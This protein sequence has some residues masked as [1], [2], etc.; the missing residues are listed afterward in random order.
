MDGRFNLNSLDLNLLRIFRAIHVTGSVSRAGQ[1][2]GMTQ[3]AVSNAL[4]RL[5]AQ[6]GDPLFVRSPT[7]VLPTAMADALIGPVEE[8][9]RQFESAIEGLQTF[10]PALS[11]RCFRIYVNDLAQLVFMPRL[12][13]Y[14][15]THA[16]HIQFETV[17]Q[18]V[19][20]GRR[21]MKEGQI[22]LA[23]ANWPAMGEGY[24]RQRLFSETFV[25]VMSAGNS[26]ARKRLS[27]TDYLNASHLDYRPSGSTYGVLRSILDTLFAREKVS[28]Q[29][30]FAAAHALGLARI[31]ADSELLLTIP[32]RLAD[33]L[34]QGST[35]AF[36]VK[37]LPFAS[38]TLQ[39]TQQWHARVQHDPANRWL[40]KLILDIF[41]DG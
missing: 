8:G 37:R 39:V 40:R 3:S 7:G 14:A 20:V 22:D 41:R 26:L 30:S 35:E 25:V 11:N 17:D 34:I 36:A 18:P 12:I 4:K 10:D 33:A 21:M 6:L 19:E 1:Q 32:S 29:V 24:F 15:R 23:I 16:P 38:P 27:K 31:L 9:L 28:R 13:A 2:I 5:R